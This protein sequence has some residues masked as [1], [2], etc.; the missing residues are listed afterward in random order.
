M[1]TSIEAFLFNTLNFEVGL[2]NNTPD[3]FYKLHLFPT[4]E[5]SIHPL[6]PPGIGS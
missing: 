5:T 2:Q 3:L 4:V 1:L 6:Y